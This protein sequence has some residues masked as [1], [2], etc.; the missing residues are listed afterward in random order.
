MSNSAAEKTVKELEL[1]AKEKAADE[2]NKT[3]S[4]VGLRKRVGQTRG[5]NPQIIEWEA[6]DEAQPETLPKELKQFQE[7][8]DVVDEPA[9][10]RLLVLGFNVDAYTN[11]SDPLKEHVN[12]AWPADAQTQFRIVVRNYSKGANVSLDE[13]VEL[14]KPGFEKQFNPPTPA[15]QTAPTA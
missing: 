15:E 14:I 4:G 2:Y 6:F 1:E 10:V 5:K 3:L 13:A 9:L 8:T 12:L 11:A 7:V